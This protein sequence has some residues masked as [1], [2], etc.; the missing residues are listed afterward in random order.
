MSLASQRNTGP[1]YGH[2]SLPV[3]KRT[4][5]CI[6]SRQRRTAT[7]AARPGHPRGGHAPHRI[8]ASTSHPG[9]PDLRNRCGLIDGDLRGLTY[10]EANKKEVARRTACG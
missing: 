7:P 3:T 6:S 1:R 9:K 2:R 10:A 4:L 5:M 8:S